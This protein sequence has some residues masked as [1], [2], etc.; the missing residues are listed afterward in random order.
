MSGN[1]QGKE[2]SD[3]FAQNKLWANAVRTL[4]RRS[5]RAERP[6]PIWKWRGR[7]SSRG[8][9]PAFARAQWRASFVTKHWLEALLLAALLMNLAFGLSQRSFGLIALFNK[10]VEIRDEDC[11]ACDARRLTN[12]AQVRIEH[13][14][15][16]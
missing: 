8:S 5:A 7:G 11:G 1:I 16:M 9:F 2:L 4:S 10:S 13:P 3:F 14:I 12:A 6:T 15:S